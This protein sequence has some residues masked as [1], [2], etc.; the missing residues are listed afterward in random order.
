MQRT[1]GVI[2]QPL[3]VMPTL[4]ALLRSMTALTVFFGVEGAAW[5]AL[6]WDRHGTATGAA[7]GWRSAH[8]KEV[9][10]SCWPKERAR[11]A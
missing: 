5:A 9:I 8:N 6:A 3:S 1:L 7:T 11:C 2:W 4:V 10:V